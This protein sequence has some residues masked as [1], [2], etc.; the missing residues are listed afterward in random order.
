VLPDPTSAV[1]QG[2]AE[3][4]AEAEAEEAELA[5]QEALEALDDAPVTTRKSFFSPE[6]ARRRK[7][8]RKSR[9]WGYTFMAPD[10]GHLAELDIRQLV[11]CLVQSSKDRSAVGRD[12]AGLSA[13]LLQVFSGF[14]RLDV[15]GDGVLSL[16]DL[17]LYCERQ[18][19][20]LAATELQE[21]LWGLDDYMRGGVTFDEV[22]AHFVARRKSLAAEEARLKGQ[23]QGLSAASPLLQ[24]LLQNTATAAAAAAA[25]GRKKKKRFPPLL[26][27]PPTDPAKR[28][29]LGFLLYRLVFFASLQQQSRGTVHLLTALQV[30]Q[31][32]FEHAADFH[33]VVL[34]MR[35]PASVSEQTTVSLAHYVRD[36]RAQ[37]SDSGG[38]RPTAP[39]GKSAAIEF[40]KRRAGGGNKAS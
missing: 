19:A 13:E 30:M 2:E 37:S 22:R 9:G 17:S 39:Q 6:E 10:M 35:D 8:Q 40:M 31:T 32:L 38:L 20:G 11:E 14:R 36:M 3:A 1:L 34:F 25:G 12:Q 33:F 18:G 27:S 26:Q 23:G 5:C 15:D 24:S 7:Q 16:R 28:P 4:A 21:A 29:F